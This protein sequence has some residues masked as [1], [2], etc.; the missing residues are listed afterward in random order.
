MDPKRALAVVTAVCRRYDRYS[1]T[2]ATAVEQALRTLARIVAESETEA[3]EEADS[4]PTPS[5]PRSSRP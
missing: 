3:G 4:C 5:A 2:D 1:L